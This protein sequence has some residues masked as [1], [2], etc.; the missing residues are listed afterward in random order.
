MVSRSPLRFEIHET[1]VADQRLVAR[2][3][4]GQPVREVA[5]VARAAGDLLLR[6]DER[7]ALDRFIDRLIDLLRGS[8]QRVAHDVLRELLAE[9][10]RPGVVRHEHDVARLPEEVVVPPQRD[11]IAFIQLGFIN[12][13]AICQPG[14][15]M[16]NEPLL[17]EGTVRVRNA[18]ANSLA[19][20]TR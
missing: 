12:F 9:A 4:C 6:V 14:A 11:R 18:T 16:G 1:G 19:S 10:G 17:E 8:L 7:E 2:R 3:R 15:C 5:A 13:P 20:T